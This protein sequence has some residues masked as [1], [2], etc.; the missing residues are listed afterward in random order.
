MIEFFK[1]NEK[2][3]STLLIHKSYSF[4]LAFFAHCNTKIV[5]PNNLG[6]NQKWHFTTDIL[7]V[8]SN[9]QTTNLV[10][11]N[12]FHEFFSISAV[13][14]EKK[15]F[16]GPKLK[17][18]LFCLLFQLLKLEKIGG[19]NWLFSG[20]M[21]RTRYEFYFLTHFKTFWFIQKKL[22]QSKKV[23]GL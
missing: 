16:I 19:K 21:S 11:L 13:E 20:L 2:K 14:K 1:V 9:H 7:S 3:L 23:L 8:T 5:C 22:D 18:K 12:F 10:F 15:L 4:H 6:P 17:K